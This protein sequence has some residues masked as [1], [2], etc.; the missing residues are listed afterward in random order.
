MRKVVI[1]LSAAAMF[2]IGVSIA[3]PANALPSGNPSGIAAAQEEVGSVDQVHWRRHHRHRVYLS[4]G[5]YRR[6][7]FH[8]RHHRHRYW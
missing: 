8:H 1:A 6:H 3:Q 7:H 5:Y 4:Y 2:G